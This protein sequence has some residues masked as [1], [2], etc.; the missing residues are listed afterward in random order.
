[1]Y[2]FS[3]AADQ[4]A[5]HAMNAL[6]ELYY[7]GH[8]DL[9]ADYVAALVLLVKAAEFDSA[10]AMLNIGFAYVWGRGVDRSEIEALKW[11]DLA[12]RAEPEGPHRM[13]SRARSEL[14]E[15]L[16]PIEVQAASTSANKWL[17]MRRTIPPVS[18]R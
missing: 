14:A 5:V 1:V 4:G 2:W 3:Q 7:Y 10:Q 9:A 16:T 13:A 12:M 18:V 15:R 8:L 11:F 6:G 17:E